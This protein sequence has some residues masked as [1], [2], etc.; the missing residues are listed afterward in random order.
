[1]S[2]RSLKRW[3]QLKT[4]RV[5][6]PVDS[7]VPFWAVSLLFHLALIILLARMILPGQQD[8][9][10]NLEIDTPIENIDFIELPPLVEFDELVVEEVGADGD[11]GFEAAASEAQPLK[12]FLRTLSTLS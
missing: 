7:D 9:R 8:Q 3:W 11:L 2:I 5:E 6:T 4:G 10:V 1:M 12:I